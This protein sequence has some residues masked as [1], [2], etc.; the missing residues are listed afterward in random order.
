MEMYHFNHILVLYVL[1]SLSLFGLHHKQETKGGA[2]NVAYSWAARELSCIITRFALPSTALSRASAKDRRRCD[3]IIG[4]L[5]RA[6][7]VLG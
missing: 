5:S 3:R 4:K 6:S 2:R 7:I 1:L